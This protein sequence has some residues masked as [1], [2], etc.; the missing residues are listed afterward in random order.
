[1]ELNWLYS[2]LPGSQST[3][4]TLGSTGGVVATSGSGDIGSGCYISMLS[5]S[6]R[7]DISRNLSVFYP[8]LP[9]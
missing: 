9:I 7:P 6:L 3:P 4:L 5:I 1:M 2:A 8:G